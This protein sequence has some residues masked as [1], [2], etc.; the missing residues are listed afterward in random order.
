MAHFWFTPPT[1]RERRVPMPRR[2]HPNRLFARLSTKQGLTLIKQDGLYRLLQNP[3][4]RTDYDS[5]ERV[6]V[7]GHRYVVGAVEA[8]ALT[9]AGYG[10]WLTPANTYG[11]GPYGDGPFGGNS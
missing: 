8:A 9:D 4:P 6:Y 1:R 7:G 3:D 10:D 2:G 5:A 11:S